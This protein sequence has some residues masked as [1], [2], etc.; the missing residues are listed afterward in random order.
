MSGHYAH[1]APVAMLKKKKGEAVNRR[2]RLDVQENDAEEYH[3]NDPIAA[4]L[5]ARKQRLGEPA[6]LRCHSISL[7]CSRWYRMAGLSLQSTPVPSQK[8]I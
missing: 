6:L 4:A 1:K 7:L 3:S 2:A 8:S 5:A